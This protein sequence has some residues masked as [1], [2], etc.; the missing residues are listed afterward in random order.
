M[1]A[2]ATTITANNSLI[3]KATFGTMVLG[4]G[5]NLL[6][7]L[8][9]VYITLPSSFGLALSILTGIASTYCGLMTMYNLLVLQRKEKPAT[10]PQLSNEE[11]TCNYR[12]AALFLLVTIPSVLL[13]VGAGVVGAYQGF[14]LLGNAL[15]YSIPAILSV[16]VFA[17]AVITTSGLLFGYVQT[18]EVYEAIRGQAPGKGSPSP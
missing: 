3:G 15:D 5:I 4:M 1:A 14:T 6:Y 9:Y 12:K 17:A 18:K 13:T 11:I 7:T 10:P 16:S 2:Q 8:G